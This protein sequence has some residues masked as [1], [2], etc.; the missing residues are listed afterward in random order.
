MHF[1]IDNIPFEM[2]LGKR[3][4]VKAKKRE[5]DEEYKEDEGVEDEA[6]HVLADKEN[7]ENEEEYE[8][9]E[10]RG[11][12]RKGRSIQYLIKWRDHDDCSWEPLKNISCPDLIDAFNTR[13]VVPPIKEPDKN[14]A[15]ESIES[16]VTNLKDLADHA[17]KRVKK[18]NAEV[19]AIPLPKVSKYYCPVCDQ[20]DEAA[21]RR[22][23][24]CMCSMH[25]FCSHTVAQAAG[26][27]DFG[28]NCFCSLVCYNPSN[29]G[30]HAGE[31]DEE[32]IVGMEPVEDGLCA[33]E[34]KEDNTRVVQSVQDRKYK[35]SKT[36]YLIQWKDE[37]EFTW[38]KMSDLL[39]YNC[40]D[41]ISQ[42][43]FR[44]KNRQKLS[45]LHSSESIIGPHCLLCGVRGDVEMKCD[46]CGAGV[47]QRCSNQIAVLV[48]LDDFEEECFCSA[49]CYETFILKKL[50]AFSPDEEEWGYEKSKSKAKQA[51][52]KKKKY[53][54][55]KSAYLVGRICRRSKKKKTDDGDA[56]QSV[57][58]YEVR[59]IDTA[60]NN[61]VEYLDSKTLTRGRKNYQ[62]LDLEDESDGGEFEDE[63]FV[64]KTQY[65]N[66]QPPPVS[67]KEIE[68]VESMNFDPNA[69]MDAPPDLFVR[70]DGSTET[71]LKKKFEQVF[72]SSASASFFAYLPV[73]F[74]E[75]VV[76]E[77]NAYQAENGTTYGGYGL[78]KPFTID[79]MIMFI[80]IL[81]YMKLF[82]RGEYR[83]FWGSQQ[84]NKVLGMG[85]NAS[86]DQKMSLKR[87]KALRAALCFNHGVS[88][89]DLASDPVAKVRPLVNLLKQ[90]GER[91][92]DVGRDMAIDESTISCRT[93]YARRLICFN[94]RKPGGKF[95]FKIYMCCCATT[96]IALNYKLYTKDSQMEYRLDGVIPAE[97]IVSFKEDLQHCSKIRSDVM[98]ILR[99]FFGTKRIVSTDNYYTSMLLLEGMKLKGLYG[100]GTVKSGSKHFP[101][102]VML[103]KGDKCERGDYR[104]GVCVANQVL[105]ASWWDGNAVTI[106]S[107]A[108]SSGKTTVS[109][110]VRMEKE[111]VSA[112]E[113][114][115]NY[116]KNMQGVDRLDQIRQRF[117]IADGHT[118]RKWHKVLAMAFIDIA[119]CNAYLTRKMACGPTKSRDPHREFMV[120]LTTQFLCGEWKELAP[121]A[122][123]LTDDSEDQVFSPEPTSRNISSK[124]KAKTWNCK[125]VSSQNATELSGMCWK[126]RQCVVC[127]YEGKKYPSVVTVYCLEHTVCLCS[128]VHQVPAPKESWFCPEQDISCWKKFHSFYLPRQVFNHQGRVRKSSE[129]YKMKVKAAKEAASNGPERIECEETETS[130]PPLGGF[131]ALLTSTTST[132]KDHSTPS[133]PQD[134]CSNVSIARRGLIL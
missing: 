109:R 27:E 114:I 56:K 83:N 20:T 13:T 36:M 103:N 55:V 78:Q 77:T 54:S 125:F 41:L 1:A 90:T 102:H 61:N 100:R 121:D 127:R 104:M 7:D 72:Q 108:D 39:Q 101:K 62:L 22:C 116:N 35:G 113:C 25:H 4:R 110:A 59:W 86:L 40:T 63:D 10:I 50:V 44:V 71:R 111:V 3:K 32:E 128:G 123:I 117:S 79:D 14:S 87:F 11:R 112:P 122:S 64:N 88:L 126:A 17:P 107:N 74:W 49:K 21:T 97:E 12:R 119:R 92:V 80:G 43:D 47:H 66:T 96:W 130:L 94:P 81:F 68:L 60:F 8:V 105:A 45:Q 76:M 118:F 58:L 19:A 120:E 95:H 85:S 89:A 52:P 115:K 24:R 67:L 42:Y 33:G 84:E 38:V 9:E 98:E 75:Q 106:I 48:G 57:V 23:S 16:T 82:P 91:Y 15:Q 69:S 29:G 93:R 30:D 99:P 2:V 73:S 31:P 51:P 5:D 53:P 133:P 124:S 28:D 132:D 18:K 46:Q 26:L 37:E 70:R 129:L 65:V 6:E 134:D 131:V 34:Q